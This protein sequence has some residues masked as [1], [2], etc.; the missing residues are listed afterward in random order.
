MTFHIGL[1]TPDGSLLLSD[2]QSSSSTSENHGLHKQVAGPDFVLGGAGN[3]EVVVDLLGRL[4][5]IQ[6]PIGAA[7]IQ[8][9]V[10]DYLR[11][12][13][14][15]PAQASVS[16]I[17]VQ[18][19]GVRVFRPSTFRQF[20]APKNMAAIGSGAEFATR[21]VARLTSDGTVVQLRNL[22]DAFLLAVWAAEAANESLTVNDCLCMGFVHGG[23]S[24]AIGDAEIQ[25]TN[26]PM[27]IRKEW[28][29]VGGRWAALLELAKYV[30][31][32]TRQAQRVFSPVR[33]GV[34]A[35]AQALAASATAIA[36]SHAYVTKMLRDYMSW[37]DTALGRGEKKKKK[38]E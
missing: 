35:D 15:A 8:Q 5:Q 13:V 9:Q 34:A 36:M 18:D 32:E 30:Q 21:A 3:G 37:Y 33:F 4:A 10:A 25:A 31:G 24:Y 26:V 14:T 12:M 11:T 17:L 6:P 38:S 1:R 20:G 29:S 7:T 22:T 2:S 16:F 23:R 19:D 27:V 28:Q